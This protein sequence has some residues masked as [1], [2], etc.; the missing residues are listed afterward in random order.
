MTTAAPH[1]E[2]GYTTEATLFVAFELSEKTHIPSDS[3]GNAP[4][5]C[6]HAGAGAGPACMDDLVVAQ[7]ASAVESSSRLDFLLLHNLGTSFVAP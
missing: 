1:Y 6:F 5:G 3:Y 2:H 7:E 4:T